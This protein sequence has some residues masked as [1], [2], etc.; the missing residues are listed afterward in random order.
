M[1]ERTI[2]SE[3]TGLPSKFCGSAFGNLRFN[4]AWRKTLFTTEP[5]RFTDPESGTLGIEV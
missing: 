1:K 4:S 2:G 3:Q 5:H